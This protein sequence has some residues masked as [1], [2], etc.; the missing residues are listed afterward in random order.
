MIS[1]LSRQSLHKELNEK[2]SKAESSKLGKKLRWSVDV[3]PI[4]LF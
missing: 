3:D 2:I 1:S 4:D